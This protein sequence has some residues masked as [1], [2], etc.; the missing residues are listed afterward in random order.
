MRDWHRGNQVTQSFLRQAFRTVG[1]M[2]CPVSSK[3]VRGRSATSGL[4][5]ARLRLRGAVTRCAAGAGVAVFCTVLLGGG[6]ASAGANGRW[7]VEATPNP[8]AESLLNGVSCSSPRACTA[9]GTYVTGS[10]ANKNWTLAVRWNGRRWTRQATANRRGGGALLGVS[11]PR[12]RD[13]VAVG[14]AGDST[15]VERWTGHGWRIQASGSRR[16]GFLTAVSCSSPSACTAVGSTAS[17]RALAERWNGIRWVV[18][19]LGSPSD[20]LL[21]GVSCPSAA[22]CIAVGH[23]GPGGAD[24]AFAERWTKG[25]WV[26]QRTRH[27]AF[28][29]FLNAV[30]CSSP[31]ACTAVGFDET[32]NTYPVKTVAERWNGRRWTL[33][34][35]PNPSGLV[36]ELTGVSCPSSS[37]CTAIGTYVPRRGVPVLAEHWNGKHWAV[38]ATPNPKGRL[39]GGQFNGVSCPS[40][41]DCSAVGYNIHL[42]DSLEQT[43]AERYQS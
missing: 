37:G 7:A 17:N 8:A 22:D 20:S 35:A 14:S 38:Q 9:V 34:A 40:P 4:V 6:V 16:A 33:Q 15:L 13:C 10:L 27:P 42:S 29:S 3:P 12:A 41:V 26:L 32:M 11:C 43:L 5:S 28:A 19:R 24:W 1:L 21:A 25:R 2:T 23:A 39:H 30:S 36:S 18:Q 31:N